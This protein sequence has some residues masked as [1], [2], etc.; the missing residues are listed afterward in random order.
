MSASAIELRA[1]VDDA[2]PRLLAISDSAS[3][4][5]PRDDAWSAREIIG[6][7]IDSAANNHPRF[8]RSQIEGHLEFDGYA[9][10]EWVKA[11]QYQRLDWHELVAFWRLY[12]LHIASIMESAPEDVRLRPHTRHSLDRIAFKPVPPTEPATL[13]YL[14]ADYVDHVRH[15]L[16]QIFALPAAGQEAIS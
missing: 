3:A 1:A 12:N 11:Q 7:L 4:D 9:Q 8:V 2:T 16:T 13:E 5:R 6:H 14:M 15:H 10:E